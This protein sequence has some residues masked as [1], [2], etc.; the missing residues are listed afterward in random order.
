M[1]TAQ[2]EKYYTVLHELELTRSDHVGVRL[3]AI[4]M[5]RHDI[6]LLQQLIKAPAFHRITQRKFLL[7]I[8]IQHLHAQRFCKHRKLCTDVAVTDNAQLLS[9]D[10]IAAF[11]R[12]IPYA[13]M[14]F[15][16]LVRD[17]ANEHDHF[18][19]SQLNYGS[20]VA[21][22]CV[23]YS[24]TLFSGSFEIDLVCADA[25]RADYHQAL[26]VIQDATCHLRLGTNA[27]NRNV[28]YTFT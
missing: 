5:E 21:E 20:R 24:N 8:V 11:C 4:H 27:K 18:A 15:H 2:V 9:A 28:L 16:G 26:R 19:N 13:L 1:S 12:L 23:E 14:H 6:S 17:I 25:K 22:R 3:A 7:A 10:F